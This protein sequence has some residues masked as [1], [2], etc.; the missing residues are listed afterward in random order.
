MPPCCDVH[1]RMDKV[2]H[3]DECH[4]PQCGTPTGPR[5]E[6]RYCCGRCPAQG[7]PLRLK[8]VWASNPLLMAQLRDEEY[9]HVF[10][11]ALEAGP[12]VVDIQTAVP[13]PAAAGQSLTTGTS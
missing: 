7:E 13:Q 1:D 12:K 2:L 3:S 6:R 5:G 4:D 8:A 9:A 10:A 11:M